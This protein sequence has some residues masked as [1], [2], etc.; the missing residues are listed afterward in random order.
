MGLDL[1]QEFQNALEHLVTMAK[2]DGFKAHAWHRAKALDAQEHGMYRGI[3]DALIERMKA[4]QEAKVSE[5]A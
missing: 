1:E 2:N 4:T 3:K 5:T